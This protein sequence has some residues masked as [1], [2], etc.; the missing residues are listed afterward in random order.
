MPQT[1]LLIGTSFALVSALIFF[2]V[3][4]RAGA[5]GTEGE[6]G[7]A[8]NAYVMWWYGLAVTTLMGGLNTLL[9]YFGVASLPAFLAISYFSLLAICIALWGL[10]FYLAYLFTG[11]AALAVP[12]AVF[13]VFYYFVLL[14][15]IS[16]S[17]PVG[18][19]ERAWTVEIRYAT[20][21]T[22]ALYAVVLVLLVVPQIVA[23]LALFGTVFKLEDR[24]QRF[25][26]TLVSWSIIVWF[27]SALVGAGA[28]L[29]EEDWWNLTTRVI[30]LAAAMAMLWAYDPPGWLQRALHVQPYA[31][32]RAS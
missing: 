10:L 9:A 14:Y 12:L 7:L 1:T 11:R 30:G 6:L 32:G 20:P 2:F 3:G 27:G 19:D 23:A 25:R 24:S 4:R 13:Y 29:A 8:V 21:V 22:G 15:Y 18:I 16:A 31:G 28:G 5:R 17:G 26:V